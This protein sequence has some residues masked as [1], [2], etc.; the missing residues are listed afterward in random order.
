M[1]QEPKSRF[2]KVKCSSCEN[3]QVIFGSAS[4]KINCQVCGTTLA[5]P[6]GGKAIIKT[7]ILEVL[8]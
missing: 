4:S 3:E 1:L 8:G 5:E 2:L 6:T 7:Q